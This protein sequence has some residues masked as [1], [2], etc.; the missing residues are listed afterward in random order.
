[1]HSY[2]IMYLSLFL[3]VVFLTGCVSSTLEDTKV[4]D[5]SFDKPSTSVEE[6]KGDRRSL[7][8]KVQDSFVSMVVDGDYVQ[9]LTYKVPN[10]EARI[11][12]EVLI[13]KGVVKKFTLSPLN[14]NHEISN[15]YIANA[16]EKLLTLI[17]GKRVE[18]ITIPKNVG[19]SSLTTG[20]V[21]RYFES[22]LSKK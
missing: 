6:D 21:K 5:E 14:G 7:E 15:N 3:A 20:A 11:S 19:G 13:E 18:D 17:I 2:L 1:M 22:L 10:G 16:Q 9:N 4:A 8:E 12:V